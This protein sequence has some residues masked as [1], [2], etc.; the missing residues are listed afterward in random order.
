MVLL[1]TFVILLFG[2]IMSLYRYNNH[3]FRNQFLPFIY[4]N[5][6]V[7]DPQKPFTNWHE[8]IELFWCIEGTGFLS[9][10]TEKVS[11][12][13]DTVVVV[14]SN[15]LHCANTEESMIVRSVVIDKSFFQIN[16]V[17]VDKLYFCPAIRDPRL[18]E[19]LEQIADRYKNLDWNS[20]QDILTLRT[21]FQQMIELLCR[22][23]L[24]PKP[25]DSHGN[26]VRSALEYLSRNKAKRITLD[27]VAN[28]VGISKY[29]LAHQFKLYTQKSIMT[30]LMQMRLEEAWRMLR[31]G[32]SVSETAA[33]CGFETL[34]YFSTSFKN[35]FGITPSQCAENKSAQYILPRNQGIGQ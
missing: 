20:F 32:V 10:N 4:F 12:D 16:G 6:M 22:S 27:S 25:T 31:K 7:I 13:L 33:A 35:R 3:R 29:H 26:Y 34:P 30:V 18:R 24:A 23:Y 1:N 14:N 28:A 8:T 9:Y 15:V 19:F 2:A 5:D 11:I 17:P 21:L